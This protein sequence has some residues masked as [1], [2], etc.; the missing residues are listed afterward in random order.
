[1][2]VNT[3]TGGKKDFFTNVTFDSLN[4]NSLTKKAIKEICKYEYLTKV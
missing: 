1:M 3:K 4:I 2:P